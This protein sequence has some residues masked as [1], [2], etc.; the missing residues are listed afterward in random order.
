MDRFYVD[1]LTKNRMRLDIYLAETGR[2]ATPLGHCECLLSELV[3]GEA[4]AA[5][6]HAPPTLERELEI[7]PAPGVSGSLAMRPENTILGKLKIKMRLR[8][9]VR[10]LLRRVKDQADLD[11]TTRAAGTAAGAPGS[12]LGRKYIVTIQVQGCKDLQVDYADT[13]KVAPFFYYDFFTFGERYS[14]TA[15]GCNPKFGD[16]R[17]YTMD[18]DDGTLKYLET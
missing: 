6:S 2:K 1:Y 8:K 17:S 15:V 4:A 3:Y 11:N 18:F 14:T 16:S 10:E 13:S 5:S 9:P 7:F 12:T